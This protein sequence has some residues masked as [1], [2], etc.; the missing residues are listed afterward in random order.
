[1]F[2]ITEHKGFSMTFENGWT[3]SVQF[4]PMNYCEHRNIDADVHSI[5]YAIRAPKNADTWTSKTAEIAIIMPNGEFYRP[6]AWSGDVKGW[7]S[8]DD[9]VLWI[10]HTKNK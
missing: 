10:S 4:G 5:L 8:A 6:K 2:A 7:C 1:M 3:I 9:V